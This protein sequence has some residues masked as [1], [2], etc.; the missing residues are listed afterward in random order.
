MRVAVHQ[1]NYLPYLGYFHKMAQCDV[2]VLLDNVQFGTR[3]YTQ[4]VKIK[5]AHRDSWLTVP[6]LSKN[7]HGQRIHEVEIDNNQP[8]RK[9]HWK[10]MQQNY[11]K[12]PYFSQYRD[13]FEEFYTR[14]HQRL[15]Q[16]NEFLIRYL[17]GK[18]EIST[19]LVP[20]SSLHV[21]G[22]ETDRIINICQALGADTYVSGKSGRDYLDEEKFVKAN[23]QLQYH[24]FQHPVYPQLY[25]KFLPYMSVVDLLFNCG[26]NS[27]DILLTPAAAV[28][29][30]LTA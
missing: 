11:A 29:V 26:N 25:G 14:E 17:A 16:F 19:R 1:P 5:T 9:T 23:L 12:A 10:S 18:L 27:R 8:W 13:F 28:R 15:G 21:A 22:E 20:E 3:P 6:V 24:D 4:R 30:A 2:F 7:K